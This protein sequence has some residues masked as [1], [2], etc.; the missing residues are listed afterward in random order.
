MKSNFS[1][2]RSWYFLRREARFNFRNVLLTT[3]LA[4]LL[5]TIILIWTGYMNY[6]KSYLEYGQFLYM[7][8]DYIR[9]G[10][11]VVYM[12]GFF[13]F[14]L[15][16]PSFFKLSSQSLKN[17]RTS[18]LMVPAS[19]L[20]QYAAQFVLCLLLPVVL[21]HLAFLL[22]DA[23]RCLFFSQVYP[24]LH[25]LTLVDYTT[26][27]TTYIDDPERQWVRWLIIGIGLYTQSLW[28]FTSYLWSRFSFVKTALLAFLMCVTG[29]WCIMELSDHFIQPGYSP[30]S[31][32]TLFFTYLTVGCYV[33]VPIHWILAY[34]RLKEQEN[35][36]RW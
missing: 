8:T 1:P 18:E 34:F 15:L 16:A 31:R 21:Y 36:A 6:P 17:R 14:C 26:L 30:I 3:L 20:E 22:A 7:F 19:P 23:T 29:F 13:A 5:L 28:F 9:N 4:Y 27:Y 25:G 35:I 2:L 32:D 12:L 24:N 11:F 10:G 33:L